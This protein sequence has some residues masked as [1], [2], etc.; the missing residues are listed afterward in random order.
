MNSLLALVS[1]MH[2]FDKEP[3]L[4]NGISIKG[5]NLQN[6]SLDVYKNEKLL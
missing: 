2:D 3:F 5:H 1:V 6:K 4:I